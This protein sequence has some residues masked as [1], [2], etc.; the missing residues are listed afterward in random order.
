MRSLWRLTHNR[1]IVAVAPGEAG[2]RAS[3]E[4]LQAGKESIGITNASEGSSKQVNKSM[5]AL[6]KIVNLA[7]I[8]KLFTSQGTSVDSL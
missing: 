1:A 7:E 4:T 6:L 8:L 2:A 5:S 3:C